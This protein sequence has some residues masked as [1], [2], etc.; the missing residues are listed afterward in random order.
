MRT[1]ENC[2]KLGQLIRRKQK[3]SEIELIEEFGSINHQ[4]LQISE[5][6]TI[7]DFLEQ[8]VVNGRLTRRAGIY[9][10]W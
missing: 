7:H 5:V 6:D 4:D 3:F 8:L 2:L 9:Q 10:L 1:H